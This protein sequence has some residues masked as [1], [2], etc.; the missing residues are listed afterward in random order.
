MGKAESHIAFKEVVSLITSFFSEAKPSGVEKADLSAW[1]SGFG[2]GRRRNPR[3]YWVF[4]DKLAPIKS[5]ID[6]KFRKASDDHRKAASALPTWGD[7]YLRCD[8][9]GYH[10]APKVNE[11]FLRLLDKLVV[12]SCYISMSLD[13]CAR[14]ELCVHGLVKSHPFSF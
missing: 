10:K 8:L 1:F 6:E 3:V 14:L 13:E 11:S 2:S 9:E 4:F 12:L 7:I 5:D